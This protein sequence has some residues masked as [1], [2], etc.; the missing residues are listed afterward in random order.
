MLAVMIEGE[1]NASRDAGKQAMGFRAEDECFPDALRHKIGADGTRLG[2]M[3]EPV[4]ADFRLGKEQ[5][6]TSSEAYRQALRRDDVLS[7]REIDRRVEEYR[8]R[9]HL[10]LLKVLAGILGVPVT[11]EAP[12][13]RSAWLGWIGLGGRHRP[14]DSSRSAHQRQ[15]RCCRIFGGLGSSLDKRN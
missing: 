10:M 4:A 3:T 13:T 12:I 11:D 1:P 8:Q 7:Q 5:G 15:P 6:W 2:E 9:S 14:G